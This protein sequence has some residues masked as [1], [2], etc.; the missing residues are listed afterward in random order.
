M[1]ASAIIPTHS[2][3]RY[4][5]DTI[6]SLC[7]QRARSNFEI[8]VVDNAAS[9]ELQASVARWAVG[10]PFPIR[11]IP[12][13]R[14]GLHHARH[15]GARFARGTILAYLDDDVLV[16]ENWLDELMKPYDDAEVACVGGRLL[17]KW[18]GVQPEWI[19]TIHHGYFSLLDLGNEPRSLRYPESVYGCNFSIRKQVLF[20]LGGFNPDGFADRRMIWYR[21]DGEIGLL[22]KV[23][24]AGLKVVYTPEAI[25]WHRIPASRLTVDYVRLRAFDEGISS[26]YALFREKGDRPFLLLVGWLRAWFSLGYRFLRMACA[27]AYGDKIRKVQA[28]ANLGLCWAKAMYGFHYFNNPALRKHVRQRSYLE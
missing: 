17:P 9:S 12:E 15:T 19:P 2:R 5:E 26:G 22:K 1:F 3:A 7:Q 13:P 10:R 14:T 27:M 21:G 6:E 23:Y 8:V 28:R 25:V 20:D 16:A 4:L 18:E 24:A 11:Y